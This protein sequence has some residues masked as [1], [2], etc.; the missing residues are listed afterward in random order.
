MKWFGIEALRCAAYLAA[1]R[2]PLSPHLCGCRRSR[3]APARLVWVWAGLR[4]WGEGSGW[5]WGW[6]SELRP[7]ARAH[8]R[9]A[10][11][12]RGARAREDISRRR[13][14]LWVL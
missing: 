1:G 2:M 8:G 10:A 7:Q 12:R 4:D 5:V 9:P 3:A 11:P 13:L 14:Q 6:D